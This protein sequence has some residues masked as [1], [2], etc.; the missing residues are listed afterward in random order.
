MIDKIEKERKKKRKHGGDA[1]KG[2]RAA[3]Q[4]NTSVVSVQKLYNSKFA[5]RRALTTRVL[6]CYNMRDYCRNVLPRY[7][8]FLA[9]Y[10]TPARSHWSLFNIPACNGETGRF[11]SKS[12]KRKVNRG[13]PAIEV[14]PSQFAFALRKNERFSEGE[15]KI[16]VWSLWLIV[17]FLRNVADRFFT[18]E[19][20]MTKLMR[21][22]GISCRQLESISTERLIAK[23]VIISSFAYQ[24]DG[25]YNLLQFFN[26]K[27]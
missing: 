7:R 5:A 19:I 18:R 26:N 23:W 3:R 4:K 15:R 22:S 9:E 25:I 20:C 2:A 16:L 17:R 13:F 14:S 27:W 10:F 1:R 8:P 24:W 21:R 11:A 12:R 6:S